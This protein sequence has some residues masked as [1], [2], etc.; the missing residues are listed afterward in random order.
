MI[1]KER[2]CLSSVPATRITRRALQHHSSLTLRLSVRLIHIKAKP[3]PSGDDWGMMNP[4]IVTIDVQ[5]DFYHGH[6]P[7]LRILRPVELRQKLLGLVPCEALEE[8]SGGVDGV[9]GVLEM[10]VRGLEPPIP[11][12]RILEALETLPAGT[13]MLAHTDRR[14]MFLLEELPR[15]GY[16]SECEPSPEGGY[17]THIRHQ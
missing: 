3:R 13:A 2:G 7:F 9:A 17:V 16:S 15:R 10:D 8:K 6:K 5:P 1:A 4:Q 12:V 11:M 14:P